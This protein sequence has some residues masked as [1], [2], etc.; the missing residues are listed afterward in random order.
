MPLGG[1]LGRLGAILSA[2]ERLFGDSG[3][4]WTVLGFLGSLARLETLSGQKRS[5]DRPRHAHRVLRRWAPN[6]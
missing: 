1:R 2:F 6:P 4:P 3:T 5:R